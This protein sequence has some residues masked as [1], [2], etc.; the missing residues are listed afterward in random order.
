MPPEA[1]PENVSGAQVVYE[2]RLARTTDATGYFAAVPADE[3][4]LEEI[5]RYLRRCPLDEFMHRHLL[6]T[7]AALPIEKRRAFFNGGAASDPVA[8]TILA[9]LCALQPEAAAPLSSPSAL[10]L[11]DLS[12]SPLVYLR[13]ES[14]KDV[15]LHRRWSRL[16]AENLETLAPLPPDEKI[17]LPFASEEGRLSGLP[18]EIRIETLTVPDQGASE[19]ASEPIETA[20][21]TA[22]KALRRLE[23]TG[24]LS[25]PEMRHETSLSP[26][27]LL[28]RWRF[29]VSVRCGRLDYRLFG[30]Q[31][32]YG[33]GF[34]LE[35]ARVRC[36]MEIAE[37][38]SAFA[39]VAG[40]HVS[41]R[42]E[43]TPLIYGTFQDLERKAN[44]PPIDPN[45]LRLETPYQ[46][47]PI[48]W[49]HGRQ[50]AGGEKEQPVLVPFQCVFLFA[51]LDEIALFS[52]LSST[53]L[54]S[55]SSRSG[56]RLSALLEVVE[57]DSEAVGF[58]DPHRCFRL[59]AED[60][61]IS[62][63]LTDYRLRGIDVFF[64]DITGFSGIPSYKAMVLTGGGRV[65]KGTGAHLDGR[66]ALLSALTELP[67]PYPTGPPSE[68]GPADLP[69]RR[70]ETLAHFATGVA[71]RDLALAQ[72]ALL[73]NGYPPVFVEI[74]RRDL[75]I[76]VVRSLVPGLEIMADYDRFFRIGPRQVAA[77]RRL[78]RQRRQGFH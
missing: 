60:P 1:A 75:R 37:R 14:M 43:E 74:T 68:P 51:N 45:R 69:V 16:F 38:A 66:Y 47:E 41:D 53:G 15:D 29:D 73:A 32:S 72:S 6:G 55:G 76:P 23:A 28:R 50:V 27:G 52:G 36:L 40:G 9:E 10:R 54:A 13:C 78:S 70:F 8:Q 21:Q 26:I 35:T 65:I 56:A 30:E 20:E 22:D 59:S 57:R 7:V 39:G 12:W 42:L 18:P 49:I 58:Y 44:P 34:S 63:L 46:N 25:G 77:Y 5:L 48:F 31:T 17:G 62:R 64:Q 3:W 11:E 4:P 71:S 61:F 19:A 24:M 33:R 2:L 67:H